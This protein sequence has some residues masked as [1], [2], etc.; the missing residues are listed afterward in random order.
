MPTNAINHRQNN[1][2]SKV[3]LHPIILWSNNW[4]NINMSNWLE[5]EQIFLYYV[6][7]FPLFSYFY[8]KIHIL[9]QNLKMLN[10]LNLSKK[11][12]IVPCPLLSSSTE[13]TLLSDL[14]YKKYVPAHTALVWIGFFGCIIKEA[15]K[16]F[17]PPSAI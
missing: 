11:F 4:K 17:R 3:L 6:I 12:C 14:Q 13:W 7:V 5:K 10:F 16:C 1:P 15:W 2:I 8:S 9:F